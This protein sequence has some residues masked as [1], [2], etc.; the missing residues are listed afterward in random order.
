M[1]LHLI[2]GAMLLSATLI[3]CGSDNGPRVNEVEE[4]ENLEEMKKAY[5]TSKKDPNK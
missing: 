5:S 4:P 2:L 3:G 1:R